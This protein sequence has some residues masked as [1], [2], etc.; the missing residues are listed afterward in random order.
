ML[1]HIT[2]NAA[3]LNILVR[4]F[5]WILTKKSAGQ[6]K[7]EKMWYIKEQKHTGLTADGPQK[8]TS[9]KQR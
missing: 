5:G 2:N 7:I 8:K 1:L 9:K 6:S 4:A 3:S